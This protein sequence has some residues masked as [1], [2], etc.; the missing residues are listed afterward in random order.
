MG[1]TNGT[2]SDVAAH[3]QHQNAVI[4]VFKGGFAMW[5]WQFVFVL[6]NTS[7]VILWLFCDIA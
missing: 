1:H 2:K 7:G 5:V 3:F 6:E 4:L